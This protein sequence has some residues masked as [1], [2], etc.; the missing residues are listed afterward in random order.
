MMNRL[1]HILLFAL[2]FLSYLAYGDT[3]I[4]TFSQRIVDTT[5][6]LTETQLKALEQKIIQYENVKKDGAQIAVLMIPTLS[7]E[8]IENYAVRVFEKWKIGKKGNDNGILLLIAKNDHRIRIEVGYG[9]EGDLPDLKAKL[10]IN[11]NITP[12]FKQITIIKGLIMD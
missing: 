7:D 9:L 1:S 6:T 10:I 5:H 11:R 12:E 2:L 3:A 8:P 4:P